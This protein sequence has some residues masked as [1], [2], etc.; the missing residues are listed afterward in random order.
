MAAAGLA[1]LVSCPRTTLAACA[2]E[3]HAVPIMARGAGWVGQEKLRARA[4]VER[5]A[6]LRLRRIS[7]P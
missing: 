6:R 7:R 1:A 5:G 2:V 4:K 3:R